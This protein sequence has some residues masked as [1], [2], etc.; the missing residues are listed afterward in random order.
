MPEWSKQLEQAKI[1]NLKALGARTLKTSTHVQL[2]YTQAE[3]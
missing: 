2:L 1:R 3:K